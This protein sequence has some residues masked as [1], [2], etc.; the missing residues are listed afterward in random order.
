MISVVIGLVS[1][2][3]PANIASRMDPVESMR[4]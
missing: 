2:I 1:G 3:F 4:A